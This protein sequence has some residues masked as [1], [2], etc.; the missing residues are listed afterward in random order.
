MP[1]SRHSRWFFGFS[2]LNALIIFVLILA[3]RGPDSGLF[4]ILFFLGLAG[5]CTGHE[6]FRSFT[7]TM[8][9]LSLVCRIRGIERFPGYG[10]A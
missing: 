6:T 4:A 10:N 7:Y 8:V 5:A 9:I 1:T 3:G 2:L